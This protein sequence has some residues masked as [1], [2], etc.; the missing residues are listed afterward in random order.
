MEQLKHLIKEVLHEDGDSEVAYV[1]RHM[2]QIDSNHNGS[3]E[4]DEFVQYAS[5][6]RRT[7]C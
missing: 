3:I 5:E 2:A 4:F 1:I 7:I 6:L